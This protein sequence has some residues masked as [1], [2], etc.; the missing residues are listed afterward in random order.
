MKVLSSFL[1]PIPLD[2]KRG[3]NRGALGEKASS[4]AAFQIFPLHN[5]S[6]DVL[7]LLLFHPLKVSS[8]FCLLSAKLGVGVFSKDNARK[9]EEMT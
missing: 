5:S 8:S 4:E 2:R 1:S 6:E 7:L 3:R 9:T